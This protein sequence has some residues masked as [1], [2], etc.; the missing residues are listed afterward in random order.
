MRSRRAPVF[1]AAVALAAVLA[2][3]G[4]E[5]SATAIESTTF[6]DSLGVTLK[7]YTRLPSGLYLRDSV[8][9]TGATLTAGK[10]VSVRYV[11]FFP[12]GRVFASRVSPDTLTFQLGAGAVIPGFDQGIA[13]M[14]V[15]GRRMLIIPPELA[16]GE[17]GSGPV[18]PYAVTL[19][20]VEAVRVE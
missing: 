15:G 12:D 18:P 10:K 13:G 17:R 19:F 7:Q 16:Y 5:P 11:G 1:A 20:L 9:G 3:G 14:K 8:A 6:V 4:T 2:C